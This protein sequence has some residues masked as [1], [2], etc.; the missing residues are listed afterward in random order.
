M[1]INR[2]NEMNINENEDTKSYMEIE[3]L[4]CDAPGCGWEDKT[5]TFDD[6][7]E[8]VNM[9]CPDCG[10]NVLTEEDFNQCKQMAEMIEMMNMYSQ[11]DLETITKNAMAEM[12]PDQMDNVLDTMN[13]L[14][15]KKVGEDEEG[16][17]IFNMKDFKL[18]KK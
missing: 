8:C 2:F 12:D 3:G 13:D 14:K 11:K 10:E 9:A 1:K 17:E 6:Y 18:P 5:I 7:E 15:S 16:R 4:V